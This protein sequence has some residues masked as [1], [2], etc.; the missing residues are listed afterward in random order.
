MAHQEQNKGLFYILREI[1]KRAAF[2]T[3]L[4][5]TRY[6]YLI[7]PG[8]ILAL[9][10][11]LKSGED[12]EGDVIEVGVARGKTTVLLNR[13]LDEVESDKTYYAVDTFGGFVKEDVEFEKSKRDKSVYSFSGFSYN[14]RK[15]WEKVVL[16]KN[17]IERVKVIENDI[18]KI[19]FPESQ[20]FSTVFIDVDLYQPTL[21][22]LG[23]IYPLTAPGGTIIVDDVWVSESG[24]Y[25]GAK[26]AF[27]EFIEEN[28]IKN[29]EVLPPRCGIIHK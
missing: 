13:Y 14:D 23:K 6:E 28:G 11:A 12:I 8:Q 19:D 29:Y 5:T 4:F 20:R 1:L 26:Q 16:Q 24:A 21:N 25:D 7:T 27:M 22:A 2:K 10:S 9:L 15:V 17:R 18:K 3:G